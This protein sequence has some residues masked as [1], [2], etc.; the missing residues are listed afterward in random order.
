MASVNTS[1][2]VKL[3]EYHDGSAKPVA[4]AALWLEDFISLTTDP[5]A[6]VMALVLASVDPTR[7]C[8]LTLARPTCCI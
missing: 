3:T 7:A 1:V 4:A 8:A 6:A 2:T 5:I